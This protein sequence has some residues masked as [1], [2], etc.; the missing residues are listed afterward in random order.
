MEDVSQQLQSVDQARS[1]AGEV[2]RGVDGH[3]APGAEAGQLLAVTQSLQVRARGVVAAWHHHHDLRSA[4]A[5]GLPGHDDRVFAGKTEDI[6]ATGQL[7]QLGRPVAGHEYR[8]QPLQG[9]YARPRGLAHG[10]LDPVDARGDL[11][12]QINALLTSIGRL[13]HRAHVAERLA[14]GMRV[15]R[16]DL[17]PRGQLRGELG[18]VLVGD[19]AHRTERLCHD[20]IRLQRPQGI[21]VELVD[22]LAPLGARA[23]G[24]VDLGGGESCWPISDR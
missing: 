14:E 15:E 5:H 4:G 2:G 20:Q 7:D 1:G 6:L 16:D 23:H 3:H 24:R 19:G 8:V 21:L 22:R 11:S 10:E 18:D 9:G 13:G 12:Q 17:R